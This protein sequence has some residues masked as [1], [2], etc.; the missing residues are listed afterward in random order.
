MH[1]VTGRIICARE[2]HLKLEEEADIVLSTD[3][4][5]KAT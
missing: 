4:T 1:I 3:S 2:K 5:K